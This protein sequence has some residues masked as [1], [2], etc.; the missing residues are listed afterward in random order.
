[1]TTPGTCELLRRSGA[2]LGLVDHLSIHRYWVRGGPETEFSDEQY[3]ALLAEA[4]ATEAFVA[5]TPRDHRQAMPGGEQRMGIALD[6]WGVWHP[7]ARPGGPSRVGADAARRMTYE[8]AGT[9]RD[10]LAA[11]IALEGFHRQC[12]VLTLAN[13]AQVVNVL[14]AAVMTDGRADVADADL[15]RAAAARAAHRRDRAA[16]RV[17]LGDSL[18][19]GSPAVSATASR[20]G[21]GLAVTLINRHRSRAADV[22]VD[23][24]LDVGSA[25]GQILTAAAPQSTN[26]ADEPDRVALSELAVVAENRR[27]CRVELPPHS[28]A[29][30]QIR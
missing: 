26:C 22:C 5:A 12:N 27:A 4:Q 20:L 11:A 29:T 3:Y 13:L 16:G 1:M 17:E 24:G 30:I 9:L 14:Q 28:M 23:I 15:P 6:E 2:H 10:A 21:D 8:Q 7:E 25:T 19:D 18:P